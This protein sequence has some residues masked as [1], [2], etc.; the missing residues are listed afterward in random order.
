MGYVISG[1]LRPC[2]DVTFGPFNDQD[3]KRVR[4][5]EINK[6]YYPEVALPGALIAFN[7]RNT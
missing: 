1:K 5:I 3:P 2:D 4:S 6:N 7:L